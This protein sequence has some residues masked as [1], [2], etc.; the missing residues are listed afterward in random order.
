M[1]FEH[2]GM[3]RTQGDESFERRV[4]AFTQYEYQPSS[5]CQP[6]E[7]WDLEFRGDWAKFNDPFGINVD[8]FEGQIQW[9]VYF[10]ER[11]IGED[12]V[13]KLLQ[14]IEGCFFD[15]LKHTESRV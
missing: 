1:P 15:L 4:E 3:A 14:D 7:G 6:R 2:L 11:F 9:N 12:R 5:P 13:G 10:D 8:L